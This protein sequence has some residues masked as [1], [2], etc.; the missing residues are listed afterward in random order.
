[1][2]H[3]YF[4]EAILETRGNFRDENGKRLFKVL[5]NDGTVSK[6]PLE[7]LVDNTS[8]LEFIE[9]ILQEYQHV[10]NN[11]PTKR[12]YC[13]NC[14]HKTV[15]GTLFCRRFACRYMKTRVYE[16]IW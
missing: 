10:A 7:S 14:E 6:E 3:T 4:A 1:M 11:S 16:I 9:P 13:L 5:W 15:P 2:V 12:R 8:H